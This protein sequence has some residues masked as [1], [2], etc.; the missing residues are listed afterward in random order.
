MFINSCPIKEMV[1]TP[2]IPSSMYVALLDEIVCDFFE[3]VDPK[4]TSLPM[5]AINELV[6]EYIKTRDSILI[7]MIVTGL[8]SWR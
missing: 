8:R 5:K 2:T 6:E 1:I 7:V 4:Y 3:F